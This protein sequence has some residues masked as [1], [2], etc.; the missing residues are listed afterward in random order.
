MNRIASNGEQVFSRRE[1][2]ALKRRFPQAQIE[3]MGKRLCYLDSA[4]TTL[5]LD[6]FIDELSKQYQYGIANVHRGA[7]YLSDKA[8]EGFEKTRQKVAQFLGASSPAE[9]V[10]TKG[11]TEGLNLLAHGLS[12]PLKPGDEIILTE[13]EHHANLVSWQLWCAPKQI[14]IRY[15]RLTEEGELDLSHLDQLLNERTKVVSFS[16]CSNVLGTLNPVKEIVSR[17]KKYNAITVVDAAQSVA[18]VPTDVRDWGCDFLVFSAHKVFGPHGV[19]VLFGKEDLLNSLSPLLG[20]GSMIDSVTL[21]GSTYLKSPHR[22]EAGTPAIPEVIAFSKAI[23]FLEGEGFDKLRERED[24]LLFEATKR[25]R[26]VK[27]VRILGNPEV[28]VNILPLVFEDMH[29]SDVGSICDQEGVAIRCGHLCALPLL[30]RFSLNSVA[31][32]SFSV[33]SDEEDVDRLIKALEKAR[34]LLT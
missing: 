3:I 25:V 20:G 19:G 34:C 17:A 33:Y 31:R 22:F 32:V 29:S 26:E 9:I 4:A 10:F 15:V 13:M 1:Q 5:K 16:S 27:G 18:A 28:R 12:Q 6:S 23:E 11:T 2:V 8:T 14:T 7:H 30:N 24:R 21:S